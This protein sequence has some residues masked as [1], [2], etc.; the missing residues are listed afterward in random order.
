MDLLTKSIMAVVVIVIIIALLYYLIVHFGITTQVSEAEA[1]SLVTSDIKNSHTG[2]VIN[3][4]N[5]SPSQYP[6]SWHIIMSVIYNATSP[7]PSF[8]AYSFDYP[9]FGFVYRVEN[10]YT[11]DCIV[12]G[13]LNNSNYIIASYP[14]AIARVYSFQAAQKYIKNFGYSNVSASASFF[15]NVSIFGKNYTNVWRVVYT[16]PKANYSEQFYITQVGGRLIA[17]YS[18]PS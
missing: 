7:C 1:I 17:N 18:I 5:V 13:F 9:K 3:I 6:G 11:S 12:Y 14:V 10:N 4:T 16:S 15:A 8:Y 2:A